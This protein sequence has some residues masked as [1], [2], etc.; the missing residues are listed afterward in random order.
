MK[1]YK[2]SQQYVHMQFF[3]EQA[4][5]FSPCNVFLKIRQMY[6][7]TKQKIRNNSPRFQAEKLKQSVVKE[8]ANFEQARSL[9][10]KFLTLKYLINEQPIHCCMTFCRL[11]P[12]LTFS[13]NKKMPLIETY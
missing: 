11:P 7:W 9:F 4:F 1:N 10:K 6:T 5:N 13:C 2:Y 3:G 12:P 8:K